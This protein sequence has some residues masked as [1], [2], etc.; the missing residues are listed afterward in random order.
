M[1]IAGLM[2]LRDHVEGKHEPLKSRP[3]CGEFL[4]K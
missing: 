3:T 1:A 2:G 4:R